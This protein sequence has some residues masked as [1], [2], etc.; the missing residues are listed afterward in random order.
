VK[1][2]ERALD[3]LL[4][5]GISWLSFVPKALGPNPR[6][7]AAAGPEAGLLLL[8]SF[9]SRFASQ[10]AYESGAEPMADPFDARSTRLAHAFVASAA[11]SNARVVYPGDVQLDL[12]AWLAAAQ[13]Q[14]LSPL[15]TGIRPDCGP[16]LAVRAALVVALDSAQRAVLARRFAPLSPDASPC[17]SCPTRPCIAACP[18]GAVGDVGAFDLPKCVQQR[19]GENS[20]CASRCHARLACPVG[21]AFR[22]PEPQLRYHYGVSLRMLRRYAAQ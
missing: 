4:D 21:A 10:T 1:S 14:Y 19:L 17:N 18:A 13:A 8:L 22:Y 16:W 9:G 6:L 5:A 12:R 7:C 3:T 15:G 11:L 20:S 2:L